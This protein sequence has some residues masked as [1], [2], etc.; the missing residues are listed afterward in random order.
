MWTAVDM[1]LLLVPPWRW[2]PHSTDEMFN[3]V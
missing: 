1:M 3:D 2:A